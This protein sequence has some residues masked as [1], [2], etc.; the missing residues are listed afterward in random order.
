MG[1]NIYFYFCKSKPKKQ[2]RM[3]IDRKEGVKVLGDNSNRPKKKKSGL[4]STASIVMPSMKKD[5]ATSSIPEI[6]AVLPIS[7]VNPISTTHALSQP[8]KVIVENNNEDSPSEGFESKPELSVPEIKI[9]RKALVI[10]PVQGQEAEEAKREHKPS[11]S[12]ESQSITRKG[13]QRYILIP[14]EEEKPTTIEFIVFLYTELSIQATREG[15]TIKQYISEIL[16]QYMNN[17]VKP[18]LP[19][20]SLLK[21]EKFQKRNIELP[22]SLNIDISIQAKRDEKS[23]KQFVNEIL[24][25]Y[26]VDNIKQTN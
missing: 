5:E 1:T 4:G 17:E 12:A 10:N 9:E 2:K 14:G 6:K 8:E 11:D 3:G 23:L 24:Y 22:K 26:Y 15:K 7:G 20:Y 25:Q 16:L 13:K 21:N 19:D 18:S